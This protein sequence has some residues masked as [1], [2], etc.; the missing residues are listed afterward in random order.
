MIMRHARTPLM[1]VCTLCAV[2]MRKRTIDV[3]GHTECGSSR[4]P[5]AGYQSSTTQ[6]CQCCICSRPDATISCMLISTVAGLS[7]Q[8]LM[9]TL[10]NIRLRKLRFLYQIAI[11]PMSQH[12]C[13]QSTVITTR[14]RLQECGMPTGMTTVEHVVSQSKSQEQPGG[15]YLGLLACATYLGRSEKRPNPELRYCPASHTAV[16]YLY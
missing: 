3:I 4:P 13:P 11:Y 7:L 14:S 1:W 15:S 16:W 8:I 9:V 6:R 10:M 2:T 5:V 12:C